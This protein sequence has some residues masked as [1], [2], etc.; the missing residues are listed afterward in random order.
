MMMMI[1]KKQVKKLILDHINKC[2]SFLL[3]GNFLKDPATSGEILILKA[4]WICLIIWSYR[5]QLLVFCTNL[6]VF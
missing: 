3:V 2:R 4:S 6:V 5:T 1:K